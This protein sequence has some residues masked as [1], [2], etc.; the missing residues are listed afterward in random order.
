MNAKFAN[1]CGFF[2]I[3]GD[4]LKGGGRDFLCF[5]QVLAQP[6]FGMCKGGVEGKIEVQE[7]SL[8]EACQSFIASS[9]TVTAMV[10]G[11]LD[12]LS[13]GSGGTL[14]ALTLARLTRK[15]HRG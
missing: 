15:W 5:L 3:V 14:T 10:S 8:P 2:H 13:Q 11:Q 4:M 12:K 1:G 7:T 9:P 6:F